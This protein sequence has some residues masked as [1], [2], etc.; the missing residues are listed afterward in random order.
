MIRTYLIRLTAASILCAM[1]RRMVPEGSAGAA[2]RLG[3]GLLL[4]LALFRPIASAD[5]VR[6]AEEVARM[7]S[8]DPL[9]AES[10]SVETNRL[11]SSLISGQ[12]EAYILDKA[13]ELGLSVQA[14]VEMRVSDYYPVP[15]SVRIRGSPTPSQKSALASDIAEKLGI[16]EERQEWWGM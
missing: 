3:A 13:G 5:P 2:A 6:A 12:A 9:T 14:E 15:W 8:Y 10:F 7:A 11:L 1:I 4:L 16:P